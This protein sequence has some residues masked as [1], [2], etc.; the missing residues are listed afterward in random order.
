MAGMFGYCTKTLKFIWSVTNCCREKKNPNIVFS[1]R[2]GYLARFVLLAI[3]EYVLDARGAYF[4][5]QRYV[6]LIYTI[7]NLLIMTNKEEIL[8]KTEEVFR[9]S[10]K[11]TNWEEVK[12]KIQR[13]PVLEKILE[14][15]LKRS[16]QKSQSKNNEHNIE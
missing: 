15:T 6:N 16:D 8:R 7:S 9:K 2:R 1:K 12:Q 5:T 4:L 3:T 14:H 11:R 13:S 10:L